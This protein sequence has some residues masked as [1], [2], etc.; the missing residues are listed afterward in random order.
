MSDGSAPSPPLVRTLLPGD[1]VD[2][3]TVSRL[4]AEGA[5]G[6]VYLAQD[7]RLG[8]QV[9]LKFLKAGS[10][11]EKGLS[12]FREEARTTAR[13]N[14]PH[15]VTV[16]AAGAFEGRPWLALEYLDGETLRE[17]L[18]RGPL[19]VFEVLRIAKA[20]AEALHEAHGHGV[21][22]ADLKPENVLLPR[23]G[24]VRVVDFGLARLIGTEATA[25]SG[26]PSYMAPERWQGQ[27][28]SPSMDVWALGVIVHEAIEARRP[29]SDQELAQL[30][31]SSRPLTLGPRVQASSCASLVAD[32][33]LPDPASRP[34]ATDLAAR[35]DRL[36]QGKEIVEGRAPFRGLDA[37]SEIDAIDF[38]GRDAEIDAAVERLRTE[39]L[40]ALVGPLAVGK[41]SFVHAGLVPRLRESAR[42]ELVATRPGRRPW[43]SLATALNCELQ[44]LVSSPGGLRAQLER[45][46]ANGAR[47]L[48]FIDQLEDLAQV[49]S[50]AERQGVLAA[51]AQANS[52]DPPWRVV[53]ALRSDALA[54]FAGA[55]E[56]AHALHSALTLR[57]LGRAALEEAFNAPLER[58]DYAI[59]DVS[60]PADLSGDLDG[61]AAPLP[62]FQLACLTLWDRRDAGWRMVLRRE[63]ENMRGVVGALATHAERVISN[64]LPGERQLARVLLLRLLTPDGGRYRLTRAQV[65]EGLPLEAAAAFERLMDQRLI[66]SGRSLESGEALY[67]LAHELLVRAW[68]TLAHWV[69]ESRDVRA[70]EQELDQAA[71]LWDRR[72]RPPEET[73]GEPSLQELR[74]R[75]DA[76]S[77]AVGAVPL[78]FLE[79]G[80]SWHAQRRGARRRLRVVSAVLACALGLWALGATLKV[81]ALAD[82]LEALT[83]PGLHGER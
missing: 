34:S 71:R 50:F 68:P 17:R 4:V 32:C 48:L 61:Q 54:A 1:V 57:P 23:D 27:P 76:K 31:F 55:A 11:D 10:L 30:A 56:L 22:H 62:L 8:R 36:L 81:Q 9:A 42:W 38:H 6:S 47:V 2:A 51:L 21:V 75:V 79:S 5:M 72:G 40:L 78:A 20:T 66:S 73:W 69:E 45:R 53:V 43:A 49:S 13:F 14:H 44:A 59:D 67:E 26:T 7:E 29:F 37:F 16:Y 70:L 58:L 60:L 64:L 18:D 25:G 35:L 65:L 39:P 33:L 24:R 15:I 52:G 83:A 77:V 19:P 80:L 82:R 74:R 12:R 41:S 63:F 28:P 46:A 3:F